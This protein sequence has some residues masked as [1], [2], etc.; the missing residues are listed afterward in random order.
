MY[1]EYG[2]S[3]GFGQDRVNFHQKPGGN[4]VRQTDPNWPNKAGYLT[5]C[6]L[7]LGSEQGSWLG[8]RS[9]RSLGAHTALGSESYFVHFAICFVY[10]PYQYCC[11]YCSLGLLFC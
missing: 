6:A 4:T 11:N 2:H 1:F 5:P 10:S 9:G 3:P 8:G 7:M